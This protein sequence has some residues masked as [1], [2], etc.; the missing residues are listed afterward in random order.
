MDL[1]SIY[2]LNL[3]VT[4]GMFIVLIFRAWIEL[5][6]YKMMWK[7]LEWKETYR[8]VGRV[9]K[10]EKDLFTKVEGGEE[11]YKLL[12]EIFKVSED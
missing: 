5:K 10:A 11:L 8:A 9:L 1:L 3:I 4:V 2:L 6:N 7:E 12:C